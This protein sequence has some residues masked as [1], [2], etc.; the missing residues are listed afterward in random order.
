[1]YGD[2]KISVHQLMLPLETILKQFQK[3]TVQGAK[4]MEEN[5]HIK[6]SVCKK[7]SLST[8]CLQMACGYKLWTSQFQACFVKAKKPRIP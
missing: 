7:C 8:T 5:L 3:S 2:R 4:R 6:L 1:M